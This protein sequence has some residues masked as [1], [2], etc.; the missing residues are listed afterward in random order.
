MDVET[1]EKLKRYSLY[2]GGDFVDPER[3]RYIESVNPTTGEAW[4]EIPPPV[5]RRHCL[6]QHL[7][8]ALRDVALW[9]FKDR[10][11]GKAGG[12]EG[13]REYMRLKSVWLHVSDTRLPTPSS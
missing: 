12:D 3:G 10:G 5:E 8:C 9:G 2:I 6:G 11:Y 4:Y 1:V 13:V 7:S